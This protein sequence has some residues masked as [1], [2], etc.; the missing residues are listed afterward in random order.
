MS[1]FRKHISVAATGLLILSLS[2]RPNAAEQTRPVANTDDQPPNFVI[3]LTDDLG[4]GD[5]GCYGHPRIQTPHLDAFAKE[6]LRL[7]QCYAACSVCSPSRS[8]I[9]TGRTPYRNGVWRWIPSGSNIHLRA[10]EVTIASLLQKRG[11]DTCHVGKWHLNGHFNSDKQPQPD[12]HGYDHWLATQNNAAPNHINPKNFVRNG[13]SVGQMEGPSSHIVVEEAAEWLKSRPDQGTPFFLTVW[14][15][16]PHLPIETAPQF[17]KPY[18]DLDDEGL[19]QHHGNVTQLDAAFGKLMQTLDAMGLRE[20][21]CVVFTSDNGPEGAGTKGRTRGSTGGLRGRKRDTYE[22]GIRVPGIIRWPGRV[23]AGSES[24]EPVIGSDLFTTICKTLDIPMP[25]DRTIDGVSM[26]PLFEGKP[27]ERA[28]PLYWRNHLAPARQRMALRIGEWKLIG[29]EDL[30]HFELYNLQNDPEET[31][32]LSSKHPEEFARLKAK[33]LDHDRKVLEEGP[34][35]WEQEAK[36]QRKPKPKRLSD[37][38]DQTGTF[39]VIKGG[40]AKKSDLGI[41]LSSDGECLALQKL[42]APVTDRMTVRFRYRSTQK[43]GI[44]RNAAWVFG[45]NP[46][47][48]ETVKVGTA[49]GLGQHVIFLGDW[50]QVGSLARVSRKFDAQQIFEA[51]VTVDLQARTV[52]ATIDGSKLSAKLPADLEEIRYIGY[53][54]KG[55]STEFTPLSVEPTTNPN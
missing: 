39:D 33:L 45:A 1:N 4:W 20:N 42:K 19:R 53:H 5:L 9:L 3:F 30:T 6:G 55:T 52:E 17:M 24:D 7:T 31:M 15:H 51:I 22:G 27:I 37:G 29:S 28:Q 49:I 34:D 2:V 46:T 23:K 40:T 13:E 35:W 12:D 26:L 47:N 14:T 44:T 16:E 36:Q 11:Y 43:D 38:E 41:E 10:S 54:V 32:E 50:R 18:A 8:A 25:S 48:A 21:T